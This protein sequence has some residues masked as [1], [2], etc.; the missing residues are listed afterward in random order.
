MEQYE[1]VSSS[2]FNVDMQLKGRVEWD[3]S[4][5]ANGGP[6]V[7]LSFWGHD[8]ELTD[9]MI[10]DGFISTRNYGKLQIKAGEGFGMQLFLTPTQQRKLK[11]LAK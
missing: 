11:E 5:V 7:G 2:E 3:A 10:K 9:N 6:I 4:G 1:P 8:I